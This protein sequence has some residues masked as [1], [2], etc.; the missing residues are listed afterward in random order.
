[1]T[2]DVTKKQESWSRRNSCK[3]SSSMIYGKVIKWIVHPKM[4]ILSLI[5]H[6][7][8]LF[9]AQRKQL[10]S[11]IS[12]LLGQFA[13]INESTMA[14]AVIFVFFVHKKCSRSFVKLQLNHW[15]HMDHFNNVL[16]AFLC[17]GH[18]RT[19]GR[20][21]YHHGRYLAFFKYRHWPISFSVWPMHSRWD[22]Y[23]DGAESTRCSHSPSC[24]LSSLTVLSIR[25]E[26]CLI[27]R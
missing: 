21:I 26:V 18:G 14:H 11:T 4:K 27:I 9:C 23:F 19:S 6:T 12:S 7:H 16:T 17:L 25:I 5:A 24:S 20:P 10:Y 2:C 1:M 3:Y 8:T 22:F 15:S 13:A